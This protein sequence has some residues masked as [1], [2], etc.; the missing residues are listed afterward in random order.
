MVTHYTKGI[1]YL[2][3]YKYCLIFDI[4]EY[5]NENYFANEKTH[6]LEEEKKIPER[7]LKYITESI[8]P[9][10]TVL[11]V[12]GGGG[13]FTKEFIRLGMEVDVVEGSVAGCNKIKDLG[14]KVIQ[15]DLRKELH[16]DKQYDLV[17]CME[18]AEHL[19]PPFAGMLINNLTKHS[20]MIYFTA[21]EPREPHM[22]HP[23]E[24]PY[25]Y[26][27]SLFKYYNFVQKTKFAG[28]G[29]RKN[30]TLFMKEENAK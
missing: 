8:K 24:Q 26:W 15:H 19:E 5:Y 14:I 6:I 29:A 12:G 22:H 28:S 21:C 30:G 13:W 18:V 1:K 27:I 11:E 16:L 4:E 25:M 3:W 20:D 2:W 9:I 10:K 7:L 23:N 17:V